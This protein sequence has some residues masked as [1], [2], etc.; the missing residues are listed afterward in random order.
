MG[1][2]PEDQWITR[3]GDKCTAEELMAVLR[4][5]SPTTRIILTGGDLTGVLWRGPRCFVLL[6]TDDKG[7]KE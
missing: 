7:V 5:I 1:P 4:Q 3:Q 6:T 2:L